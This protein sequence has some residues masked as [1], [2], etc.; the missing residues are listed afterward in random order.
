MAGLVR[1]DR[2]AAR[3]G[4]ELAVCA[5]A[6]ALV[7]LGGCGQAAARSAASPTPT[8]TVTRPS[9]P[10]ATATPYGVPTPT[11]TVIN[12]SG[13]PVRGTPP[14]WHT[15]TLPRGFGPVFHA[16]MLSVAPSD[17][18]TGY[19]CALPSNTGMGHPQVLATHDG[20]HSWYR[21]ADIPASWYSCA[22]LTVD[23]LD[24]WFVE[25]EPD[26]GAT[27]SHAISLNGGQSWQMVKGPEPFAVIDMATRNGRTYAVL[28]VNAANGNGVTM[29]VASDDQLRT[30]RA[31]DGSLPPAAGGDPNYRG[32]WVN[33]AT[34][35]ILV[36]PWVGG[37]A[38]ELWST[39][40]E[41]RHWVQMRSPVNGIVDFR[42][43]QPQGA[44]PWHICA[45]YYP[46]TDSTSTFVCTKDSG[47][48]WTQLPGLIPNGTYGLFMFGL[49][50]DGSLL[51][52]DNTSPGTLYR[53]PAGAMRWQSLGTYPDQLDYPLFAPTAS[54]GEIW[55]VAGESDG[56]GGAGTPNVVYT[57]PIGG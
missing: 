1:D 22:S 4:E 28:G 37:A 17:G 54:G 13:P 55:V 25:A 8:A 5:L 23:A 57:A 34:G 45:E 7:V 40:D 52:Y 20:A 50:Q 44:G 33:P 6:F 29:L 35:A 21:V 12:V 32:L 2:R 30:W 41:G 14:S 36:E 10:T 42:V 18:L 38:L 47:Q 19:T 31:I 15:S 39:A 11:L 48:S 27:D 3:R 9:A 56:A 53:W 16:S 49:P 43:Q 46:S 26:Y 24:P 51:A